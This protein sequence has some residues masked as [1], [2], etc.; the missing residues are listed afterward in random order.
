MNIVLYDLDCPEQHI[1]LTLTK[2]QVELL[3]FLEQ[4][5]FLFENTGVIYCED[6]KS[7]KEF[8]I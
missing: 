7:V 4:R 6:F 5:E 1:D 2:E 3:K 8:D